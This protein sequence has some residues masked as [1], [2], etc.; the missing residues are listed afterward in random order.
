MKLLLLYLF[1]SIIRGGEV[2]GRPSFAG[3]VHPAPV[4]VLLTIA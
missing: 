1:S 3:L 4:L 2:G